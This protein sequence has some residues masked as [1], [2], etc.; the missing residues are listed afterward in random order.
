M[1]LDVVDLKAFYYRTRLGRGAQSAIQRTLRTLWPDVSGQSVVGFGFAAPFLRPFLGEAERVM[2]FMPAP[3]GVMA[4]PAG[5][6]NLSALVE[7]T[8]WPMQATSIDRIIVAHGLET[9]ER[10]G[11]LLEEIW[12]V[13]APG[14]RV[15]FIVPNRTGIWAQRDVTPFGHGRPY[16]FGQLD[17]QLRTHRFEPEEHTAALYMPPSHRRFLTRMQGGAERLGRRLKA[18][19]LGGALVV[20]AVKQVHALPRGPRKEARSPISLL[21]GLAAPQPKPSPGRAGLVSPAQERGI[22]ARRV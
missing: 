8:H 5:Q 4:W 21:G 20:E 6:P 1:H 15:V 7:E 19:R 10:P 22:R 11:A 2:S 9:C 12:R 16:S 17:A 18:Y 13:L 3:Q 14:G